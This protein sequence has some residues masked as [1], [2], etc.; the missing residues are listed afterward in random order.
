MRA[1]IATRRL[2]PASVVVL[3]LLVFVCVL[4]LFLWERRA[5]GNP[6]VDDAYITFSFSKNLA[7]GNGPVYSHGLRVEGYSNFLWMLIVAGALALKPLADPYV[8]AR[9]LTVPFGIV[10]LAS[11]YWLVLRA[12]RNAKGSHL[13]AWLVLAWMVVDADLVAA[14]MSGL[15]TLP[16]AA[17]VVLGFALYI[18]QRDGNERAAKLTVPCLVLVA[19]MRIDGFVPLGFILTWEFF[20]ALRSRRFH[21]RR[22]LVWAGPALL[23][24]AAWFAWRWSYYGLPLPTTYYAKALIPKA[25]PNRGHEYVLDFWWGTG[26]FL[27]I[28]VALMS[29]LKERFLGAL[30]LAFIGVLSLYVIRVGGDWMPFNRFFVSVVPLFLVAVASGTHELLRRLARRRRWEPVAAAALLAVA[31]LWAARRADCHSSETKAEQDKLKYLLGMAATLDK[32]LLP[33]ARLLNRVVPPGK[34]LVSDYAGVMAYFT[35]AEVIDMWGLANREIALRGTTDGVNPIWGRTCPPCYA[36]LK[37]DF[38]HVPTIQKGDAYASE[39]AVIRAVW[40]SKAIGKYV[41]FHAFVAGRVRE[42]SSGRTMY[43][44]QRKTDDAEFVAFEAGRNVVVE[45]P[46]LPY[47]SVLP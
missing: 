32:N 28:P 33:A 44:L 10:F 1:W 41:D 24:Y 2:P 43:F 8:A 15:E 12:T 7:T 45:Y 42:R 16:H 22:F 35:D 26:L 25:L 30:V 34:R 37:P 11:T 29:A 4:G 31:T 27:L 9:A 36:G 14:A 13:L 38:F 18:A 6:R 47:E 17:L 40:Q 21:L 3:H 46:F 20:A 39:G 23:V 19:L 5:V